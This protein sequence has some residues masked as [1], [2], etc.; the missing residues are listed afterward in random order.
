MSTP[1]QQL[2]ASVLNYGA[3]LRQ[4][5]TQVYAQNNGQVGDAFARQAM[6]EGC[7]IISDIRGFS[8]AYQIAQEVADAMGANIKLE[9]PLLIS[10]KPPGRMS[11]VKFAFA[12]MPR[13][14]IAWLSFGAGV[15]LTSIVAFAGGMS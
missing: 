4:T 2:Q 11:N 9:V 12:T 5:L 14:W 6:I 7:G 10:K 1:N 3:S 8:R 15:A 13:P